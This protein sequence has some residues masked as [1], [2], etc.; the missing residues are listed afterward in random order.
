[1]FW[2]NKHVYDFFSVALIPILLYPTISL[3]EACGEYLLNDL[4]YVEELAWGDDNSWQTLM[5]METKMQKKLQAHA[6]WSPVLFLK[7]EL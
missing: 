4:C 1:M 6:S 3:A 2:L 7:A 5:V